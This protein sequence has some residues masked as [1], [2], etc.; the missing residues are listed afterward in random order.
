[1]SIFTKKQVSSHLAAKAKKHRPMFTPEQQAQ[2][3]SGVHAV[4][5]MPANGMP[6]QN[7][8]TTGTTYGLRP[9]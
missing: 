4:A 9:M 1:M 6:S 7:P 3:Q 2:R 8:N 5:Q